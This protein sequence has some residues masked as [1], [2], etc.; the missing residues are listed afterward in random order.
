MDKIYIRDIVL[1][2]I[3]GLNADERINKQDVVI[4]ITLHADVKEAGVTDNF[5]YTVDYKA[6][7]LK[8]VD[9]VERSEFFLV[10]A[11]AES[12]AQACLEFERV[13][14]VDVLVEKPGALKLA[15]TVGVEISRSKGK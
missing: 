9:L 6:V 3:I 2:C 1:S 11:L 12:I 10:E 5:A 13:E 4:N 7:K 14:Q 8:I 15:R